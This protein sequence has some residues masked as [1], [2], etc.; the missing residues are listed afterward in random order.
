MR[1]AVLTAVPLL[2]ATACSGSS[3]RAVPTPAPTTEAPTA[4]PTTEAPTPTL[5]P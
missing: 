2:L 3:V 1:R 5:T 4:T